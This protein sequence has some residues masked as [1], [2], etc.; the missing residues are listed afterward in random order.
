MGSDLQLWGRKE[1][2]DGR[3]ERVWLP[4]DAAFAAMTGEVHMVTKLLTA[5]LLLVAT[6]PAFAGYI[7]MSNTSYPDSV[8]ISVTIDDT[9][10]HPECGWLA[11]VRSGADVGYIQRQPGATITRTVVDTNV[12]PN[13]LYCYGMELRAGPFPVPCGYLCDAFDCFY[14]ITTCANTRM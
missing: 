9:G 7:S 12:E 1:A 13:T 4:I 11:V 5:G 3:N 2:S 8:V 6:P 10:G 14:Q